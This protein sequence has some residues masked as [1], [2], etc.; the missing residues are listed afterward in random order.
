[1]TEAPAPPETPV[2]DPFAVSPRVK[3][4][5]R[6]LAAA[7]VL[8]PLGIAWW[9]VWLSRDPANAEQVE[10][11][12]RLIEI[13]IWPGVTFASA[14]FGV[15]SAVTQGSPWGGFGGGYGGGGGGWAPPW[16]GGQR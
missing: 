9:A 1:M 12:H 13:M 11:L 5:K 3:T 16:R 2:G 14:M 6:E 10:A 15:H 7:V 8:T 4:W